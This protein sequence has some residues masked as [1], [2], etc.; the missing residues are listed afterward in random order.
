LFL[1]SD[2]LIPFEF[3]LEAL[4]TL[5]P[6]ILKKRHGNKESAGYAI[7]FLKRSRSA[8]GACFT[9]ELTANLEA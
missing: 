4:D 5:V 8:A 2:P 1:S 6:F 9:L 3:K 7:R